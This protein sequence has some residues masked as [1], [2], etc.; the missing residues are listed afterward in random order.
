MWVGHDKKIDIKNT[1]AVVTH[2][3]PSFDDAKQVLFLPPNAPNHDEQS[4]RTSGL[5]LEKCLGFW[6]FD[7]RYVMFWG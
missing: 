5:S 4:D 6:C 7:S 3:L 1:N 2:T